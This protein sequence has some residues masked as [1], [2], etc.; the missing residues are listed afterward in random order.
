MSELAHPLRQEI[1]HL[2]SRAEFGPLTDVCKRALVAARHVSDLEG[3]AVAYLGLATAYRY[4]GQYAEARVLNQEGAQRLAVQIG[5]MELLTEALVQAA[6]LRSMGSFQFY[7][8]RDLYR[9]ALDIAHRSH[10]ERI[11]T[12]AML[13]LGSIYD[14]LGLHPTAK[15]YAREGLGSAHSQK[16]HVLE[17]QA[18]NIM[19]RILQR[20]KDYDL[21]LRCHQ[22]ALSLAR[23]FHLKLY[24]AESLYHIGQTYGRRDAV[25]AISHYR[26]ALTIAEETECLEQQYYIW[27]GMGEVYAQTRDF[28]SAFN[29]FDHM[30]SV[31]T[32]HENRLQEAFAFAAMGQARLLQG[33][34]PVALTDFEQMR[35]LTRENNNPLGEATALEGQA[36]ALEVMHQYSEMIQALQ[37]ARLLYISLEDEVG[38][39]RVTGQLVLAYLKSAWDRVL[40][41]LGLRK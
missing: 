24:E 3:E 31:A 7:E 9:E 22:H 35:S 34:A 15:N 33:D 27:G 32:Q 39:R 38:V 25:S 6:E 30:L 41:L 2:R 18:L 36:K 1:D 26:Q 12:E 10:Q 20:E 19:G 16:I 28:V 5:S 8:A 40:R 11:Q 21:A 29:A 4:T 13:G 14:T 37:D 17:C 23:E